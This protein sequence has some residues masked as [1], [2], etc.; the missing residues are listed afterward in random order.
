MIAAVLLLLI[1][2]MGVIISAQFVEA[3]MSKK[4]LVDLE[5]RIKG[6]EDGS[7]WDRLATRNANDETYQVRNSYEA[8][9]R[10]LS[11]KLRLAE[12]SIRKHE[13]A[14]AHLLCLSNAL[15]EANRV[16]KSA[17]IQTKALVLKPVECISYKELEARRKEDENLKKI[18]ASM[19][20]LNPQKFKE[21]HTLLERIKAD[22]GTNDRT[23]DTPA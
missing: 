19:G 9:V 3:Q 2:P 21:A 16:I 23:S 4:N 7:K 13:D 5:D 17:S 15:D 22:R 10:E 14:D 6:M 12:N 18:E 11:T 1:I 20:N 8:Q